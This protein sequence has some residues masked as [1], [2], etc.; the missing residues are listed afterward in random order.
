M[1]VMGNET[2]AQPRQR[3]RRLIYNACAGDMLEGTATYWPPLSLYGRGS[4]TRPGEWKPAGSAKES[5]SPRATRV[6]GCPIWNQL[7]P[8]SDSARSRSHLVVFQAHVVVDI[9]KS[10]GALHVH[11]YPFFSFRKIDS[12]DRG[13]CQSKTRHFHISPGSHGVKA[14]KGNRKGKKKKQIAT[15][16]PCEIDP[17]PD[18]NLGSATP[19]LLSFKVLGLLTPVQG[20]R[21]GCY[22]RRSRHFSYRSIYGGPVVGDPMTPNW[23]GHGLRRHEGEYGHCHRGCAPLP[24]R[25]G[26]VKEREA[27]C[28]L[29]NLGSP[30]LR[31]ERAKHQVFRPLRNIQHPGSR[32]DGG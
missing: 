6:L 25:E 28:H 24:R 3:S 14:R 30:A 4:T 1:R 19:P 16:E 23:L 11:T 12:R 15:D 5:K 10:P 9:L 29:L 2:I 8:P 20:R 32:R 17:F 18:R 31:R 26:R 7:F 21:S 27:D 13:R 22:E